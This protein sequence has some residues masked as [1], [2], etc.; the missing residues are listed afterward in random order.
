MNIRPADAA[1]LAQV[2]C[3]NRADNPHPWADAH[4]QAALAAGSLIVAEKAGKVSAFAAWQAVADEAELHLLVTAQTA[5]RTGIAGLLLADG[6]QRFAA[7]RL[8]LE[9]RADNLPAVALYRKHGFCTFAVR[10]NY[11]QN[12]AAD[13]LIMEKIC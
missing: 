3:I 4:F 6:A 10:K 8:L 2:L 5:R 11:Y 13:A 12:P 1:A 7:A 9:V